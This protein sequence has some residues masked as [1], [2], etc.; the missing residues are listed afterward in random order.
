MLRRVS[1]SVVDCEI[2]NTRKAALLSED[3]GGLEITGNHVRD[4]GDNGILVWRSA[5]GEDGTI[6]T[7]NRIERNMTVIQALHLHRAE[8]PER[9]IRIRLRR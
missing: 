5:A 2:G 6:V 3:A 8:I 1:G 4:C 7:G 9:A